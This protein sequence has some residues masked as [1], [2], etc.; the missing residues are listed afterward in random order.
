MGLVD[1]YGRQLRDDA[2]AVAKC[3]H[4]V[5]FDYAA[6]QNLSAHEVKR[7][8]PRGFGPCPKGCGFHGIAYAS[9]EHYICGDW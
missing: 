6:A 1:R 5:T 8:W 9:Y 3:D 7:R 4:G 2:E